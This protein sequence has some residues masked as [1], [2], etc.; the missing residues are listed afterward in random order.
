MFRIVFSC[1]FEQC[2]L[3]CF[4]FLFFTFIFEFVTPTRFLVFGRVS[5]ELDLRMVSPSQSPGRD[6]SE[7]VVKTRFWGHVDFADVELRGPDLRAGPGS[8]VDNL[9]AFVEV[10]YIY[11][12]MWN[13]YLVIQN[14]FAHS[15]A[16]T[17]GI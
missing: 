14:L 4:L 6:L 2:V 9:A 17:R 1:V 3:H 15:S 7:S 8:Y 13:T 16:A 5:V 12:Y 11:T 10:I